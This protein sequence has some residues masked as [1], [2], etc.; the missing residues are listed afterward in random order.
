MALE[1]LRSMLAIFPVQRPRACART[2]YPRFRTPCFFRGPASSFGIWQVCEVLGAGRERTRQALQGT[3][4][5][6]AL[7]AAAAINLA[8]RVA[9]QRCS[10]ATAH[11]IRCRMRMR[12][13]RTRTPS[14]PL[15]RDI[16]SLT[17]S[18][19]TSAQIPVTVCHRSLVARAGAEALAR[20]LYFDLDEALEGDGPTKSVHGVP[21]PPRASCGCLR[22]ADG[23]L[24]ARA[25]GRLR[26]ILR[27]WTSSR[28]L[29]T[30]T[31]RVALDLV[32][33]AACGCV[34]ALHGRATC[35]SRACPD[36]RKKCDTHACTSP[37]R[38]RVIRSCLA[39]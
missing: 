28:R 6:G 32:R 29:S 9:E 22:S 30:R 39:E 19:S 16:P 18:M 36:P 34:G 35:Q 10:H 1:R 3:R 24:L 15:S 8:C 38:I 5:R 4:D 31:L 13:F 25:A 27:V 20:Q 23:V 33:L 17:L 26:D 7:P 37:V 11:L 12:G 21:L 2:P 14:A